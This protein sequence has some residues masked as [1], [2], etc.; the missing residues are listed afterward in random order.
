MSAKLQK[1]H[2]EKIRAMGALVS[3][4]YLESS[5]DTLYIYTIFKRPSNIYKK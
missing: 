5:E 4:E 2:D 3:R 1:K